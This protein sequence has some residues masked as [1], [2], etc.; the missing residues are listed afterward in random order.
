MKLPRV[1]HSQADNNQELICHHVGVAAHL[2]HHIHSPSTT[3]ASYLRIIPSSLGAEISVCGF[4]ASA[5]Y[6]IWLQPVPCAI[7]A[8]TYP[9]IS[10][11][12]C[13][14]LCPSKL[15]IHLSACFVSRPAMPPTKY[16]G[17]V[18]SCRSCSRHGALAFFSFSHLS[19]T[20]WGSWSGVVLHSVS[21][22]LRPILRSHWV[23]WGSMLA[24]FWLYTPTLI[25]ASPAISYCV[26][27]T[28][29]NNSSSATLMFLAC[30][31]FDLTCCM[32]SPKLNL[33]PTMSACTSFSQQSLEM[34]YYACAQ[35]TG[36][37][38]PKP[39]CFTPCAS[40]SLIS[41]GPIGRKCWQMARSIGA[42]R[43]PMLLV[44]VKKL[45]LHSN[46][47]TTTRKVCIGYPILTQLSHCT[48]KLWYSNT[49]IQND[50][51]IQLQ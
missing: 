10:E 35:S 36:F 28:K 19:R 8:R 29:T 9:T 49:I 21:V 25:C 46:R 41:P 31:P 40:S 14:H 32:C 7:L 39:A 18:K 37:R 45:K 23:G 4:R 16:A 2:H 38:I 11:Y 30:F 50:Y 44:C 22:R 20:F 13:F 51:P 3:I 1:P 47:S 48:I 6:W 12:S 42:K 5:K 43:C 26:P 34:S 33:V 27:L 15:A 17:G 24:R